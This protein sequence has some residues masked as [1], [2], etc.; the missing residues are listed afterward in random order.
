MQIYLG[1]TCGIRP[2][3]STPSSASSNFL[4][5]LVRRL[6]RIRA[7]RANRVRG[8]PKTVIHLGQGVLN[9]C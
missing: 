3:D 2:A 4:A 6:E 9:S 8:Q 5:A 1:C 7:P